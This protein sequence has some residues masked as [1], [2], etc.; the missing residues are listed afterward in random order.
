MGVGMDVWVI[1]NMRE[2]K[3][4]NICKDGILGMMDRLCIV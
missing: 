3:G 4:I 1:K 2:F